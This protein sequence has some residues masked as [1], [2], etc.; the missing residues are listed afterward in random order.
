M[1]SIYMYTMS[2]SYVL[3]PIQGG[4]SSDLMDDE[5]FVQ[6]NLDTLWKF[7]G[8]AGKVMYTYMYTINSMF[9]ELIK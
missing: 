7:I 6:F 2:V 3:Y 1:V 8:K 4:T 9:S 5:L